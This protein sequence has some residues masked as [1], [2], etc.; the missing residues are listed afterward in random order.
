MLILKLWGFVFDNTHTYN[1]YQLAKDG[2]TLHS[3]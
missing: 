3:T 1:T 2:L